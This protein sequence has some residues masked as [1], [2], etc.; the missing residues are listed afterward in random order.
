MDCRYTIKYQFGTYEGT[1]T[2][3]LDANDDR[4]PINMMWARLD[5]LTTLPMAAQS[6]KIVKREEEMEDDED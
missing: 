5:R 3:V 4:S 2:V 6:A 1:E